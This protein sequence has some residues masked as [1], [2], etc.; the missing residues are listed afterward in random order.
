VTLNGKQIKDC[1]KDGRSTLDGS[2]LENRQTIRNLSLADK[3]SDI[4]T[5]SLSNRS[6][7]CKQL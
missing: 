2:G 4:R 1:V 5:G 7:E 3:P 6:L